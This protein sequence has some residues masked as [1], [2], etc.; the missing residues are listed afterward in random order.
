[1]F[2][3]RSSSWSAGTLPDLRIEFDQVWNGVCCT[4]S[5]RTVFTEQAKYNRAIVSD[6]FFYPF[7]LMTLIRVLRHVSGAQ[8][9]C[10]TLRWKSVLSF[11]SRNFTV[12]DVFGSD[13]IDVTGTTWYHVMPHYSSSLVRVGRQSIACTALLFNGCGFR[14]QSTNIVASR[15]FC[16]K[17]ANR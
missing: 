17:M 13:T 12:L 3:K 15:S 2:L 16:L 14:S 5:S 9:S 6:I 1:M 7:L 4:R 8:L 11:F 10:L